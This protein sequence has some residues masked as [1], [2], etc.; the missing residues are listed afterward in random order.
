[1]GFE[2]Q[3]RHDYATVA[4]SQSAQGLGDNGQA[5][6]ILERLLIVPAT[7]SAGTVS[8]KDGSNTAITVFVS[9]TLSDL[10]PITIPLS[11]RSVKG[12]WQITTGAAVSV[13][14]I[15]RFT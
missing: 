2:D 10:K 15:G 3:F 6:D 9:G 13:V 1:M 12:G 5:G 8:I 14:A 4:A 7:T 11:A